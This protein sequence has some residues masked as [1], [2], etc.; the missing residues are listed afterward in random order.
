MKILY[1]A[2]GSLFILLA[3][4]V[5][6][7][8]VASGAYLPRKY[9]DPWNRGYAFQFE[10]PRVSLIA[11]G[12]L[13]ANSHNMQ[14]WKVQLDDKDKAGFT[15]FVDTERLTPQV[16]I[17]SRQIVISQ[18]TFLEYVRVAA[19]KLGYNPVITLFPDG[20]F[21]AAG[22]VDS[23]KGKAVARVTL[24]GAEEQNDALYDAMFQPDTNRTA[25]LPAQLSPDQVKQL[26]KLNTDENISLVI[27]QDKKDLDNLGKTAMEAATVEAN[28]SR[29]ARETSVLFRPNEYEKNKY[30][31]G[32]SLE[33][34]GSSPLAIF[35]VQSLISLFPG[36]NDE[37]ATSDTFLS[38]TR[39]SVD[40]TPA[41]LLIIT[42]GN[43]RAGQVKTG[44][45]YSRFQL[46]AQTMGFAVQP[47][48]QA[49]E[50]YPEMKALYDKIHKEYAVPG[51][52]I[53]MLARVGKPTQQVATSMRR[54]V[55][56]L[57]VK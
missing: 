48:S 9:A 2:I 21:D 44:M 34:Q 26:Q 49:L 47:L 25:Y 27:L 13:A 41:Y 18:G 8:V 36:M 52:T 14:A 15:L 57:I 1:Y 16:D 51:Q 33:G 35:L 42:R 50:E 46:T 29:I 23:I 20:E 55:M 37:K 10:D 56:E 19:G 17:Y 43:S 6:V 53:Q 24:K 4:V 39:I 38:S 40:N 28:V 31:Y 3:A 30:R 32:F 22:T 5:L 11:H 7:F 12:L 54:D 45:L